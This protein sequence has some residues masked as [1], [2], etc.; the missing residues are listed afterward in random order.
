MRLYIIRH[1]DPD[2]QTDSLTQRG[3]REAEAL[4]D[5]VDRLGLTHLYCSPL[6]RARAT[7]APCAQRLG[8]SVQTLPWVREL[9]G[10]YYDLPDFGK[11][12]PFTVPGEVM[13]EIAP[14][15][16]YA[17]WQAQQYFDDP[18]FHALVKQMEQGSDALLKA[19]GY[20]RQGARYMVE[21]PNEDRVAVFCHQG[22]GTTWLAYLLNIP[23]QAAWA[24]LWQPCTGI[25]TI[26][27]ECR[28]TGYAC[29]RM[30]GM[31]ETPHIALKGLE[32]NECGLARN[33]V[34]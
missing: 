27:M 31:G 14:E 3:E 30:I 6:G 4:A 29:P 19:H 20:P 34:G 26:S 33:I 24:G 28:S 13:Y 1:G 32:T 11:V 8:L 16:S 25:T 12:A 9:T 10:I 22:I 18:R 21:R 17:H 15:P 5:Y 23:Y 7:C 2:Y